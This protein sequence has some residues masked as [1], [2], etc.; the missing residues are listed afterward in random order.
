MSRRLNS[1][2]C[3]FLL[4]AAVAFAAPEAQLHYMAA[5][6]PDSAVLL[7]P[8]PLPHSAEEAADMAV[9]VAACH[10]CSTNDAALAFGEKKFSIFTFTPAIGQF[11]QPGKLP[12]TEAFFKRL[13]KDAAAATDTAKDYWRRPRPFTLDP[14][15]ASGK[16]EKS[17]GYPSGHGTEGLVLALVR[18]ELFPERCEAI[19]AVGR[20]LGWHRVMIAR[21]YP[22]DIYAGRVFAQAIVREM[23][24]NP[25]FQRDFAA[26]KSEIAGAQQSYPGAI[27]E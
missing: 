4:S 23:K 5:G 7:A 9:V 16:L 14:S 1:S 18:A 25:E 22:T 8:P 11:L 12:Q 6:Q 2:L 19:L 20:N 15:L 17:F 3:V 13:Q 26:A 21:H 10:A 24:S 27:Q